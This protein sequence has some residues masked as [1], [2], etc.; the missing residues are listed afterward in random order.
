MKKIVYLLVLF[1][2]FIGNS[3][4][5]SID[6]DK[7][8][9]KA[10]TKIVGMFVSA[11]YLYTS[12]DENGIIKKNLRQDMITNG[13]ENIKRHLNKEALKPQRMAE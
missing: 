8:N 2:L 3:Y 7:I 12:L 13:I 9:I 4:A 11:V 5:F 6:V 1:F 10:N